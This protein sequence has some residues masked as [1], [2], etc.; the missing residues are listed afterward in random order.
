MTD[1]FAE[2]GF[3]KRPW[4]DPALVQSRYHE[5]AVQRHPDKCG[6]DPLPLARLN[7]A[8]GIL[9]PHP[10]RLRHLLAL[11][12]PAE[13]FP[14]TFRPD[15][16]LFSLV[17]TLTR[18]AE[19]FHAKREKTSSALAA[20]VARTEAD[21]LDADITLALDRISLRLGGIEES[22]RALDAAWPDGTAQQLSELAEEGFFYCKWQHALLEAR[23]ILLGG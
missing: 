13:N 12:S 15:F 11:V 7:E 21:S 19:I 1:A 3:E 9:A 8:R 20:A 14:S 17:G 23:T 2:F 22:I 5:L 6:G 4:L 16:D 10:S 18:R